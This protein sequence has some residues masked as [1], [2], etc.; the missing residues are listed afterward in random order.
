MLNTRDVRKKLACLREK[1]H[2]D[3]Q[4]KIR[5]TRGTKPIFCLNSAGAFSGHPMRDAN[6]VV[7]IK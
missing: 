4:D 6:L 5:I 2:L 7:L 3:P 1:I